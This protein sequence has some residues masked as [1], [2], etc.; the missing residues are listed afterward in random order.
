ME[1]EFSALHGQSS[2]IGMSNSLAN[3]ITREL[4]KQKKVRIG[5]LYYLLYSALLIM[6]ARRTAA[7]ILEV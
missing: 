1:F 3:N 4:T 7:T 2:R 5:N 6:L